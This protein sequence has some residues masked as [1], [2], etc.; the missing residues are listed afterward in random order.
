MKIELSHKYDQKTF[1]H[2]FAFRITMATAIE[3]AMFWFHLGKFTKH[4]SRKRVLFVEPSK[5]RT[6][7]HSKSFGKMRPIKVAEKYA[8]L[9]TLVIDWQTKKKFQD[10]IREYFKS[11]KKNWN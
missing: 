2:S 6:K 1:E 5:I 11:A 3:K 8:E 7:K 4:L 9:I 10:E